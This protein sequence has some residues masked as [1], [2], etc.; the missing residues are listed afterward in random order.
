[1]IDLVLAALADW[2]FPLSAVP[3][4]ID[5]LEEPTLLAVADIA[6]ANTPAAASA[7]PASRT[8]PAAA[9]AAVAAAASVVAASVA[10]AAAGS[11]DQLSPAIDGHER[12]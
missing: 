2:S 10:A 9:A 4:G 6:D 1:L 8:T 12:N 7:D 11:R 5:T 3:T